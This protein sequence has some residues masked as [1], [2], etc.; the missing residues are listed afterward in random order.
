VN[1]ERRTTRRPARRGPTDALGG[2]TGYLLPLF[3]IPAALVFGPLGAAGSPAALFGLGCLGWWA[4]ARMLPDSWAA[5][6]RQPVRVALAVLAIAMFASYLVGNLRPLAADE[7]SSADR[8]LLMLLS[9]CGLALAAADLL[10]TRASV[11]ALLKRIVVFGS[12]VALIGAVQ[13]MTGLDPSGLVKIPGL[14]VNGVPQAIQT[15]GPIRRVAGTAS[16]P[17]EY[18]MVLALILPFALHFTFLATTRKKAWWTMTILIGV[19]MPMSLSRSAMLGTAVGLVALFVIWPPQRRL[20]AIALSP[21]L[22]VC[23]R[24]AIP[25]LVGTMFSLFSNASDDPSLQGRADSRAA[26]G[27]LI[28]KSPWFGRGFNTY[29]PE[30]FVELGLKGVNHG[31]LDNQ[32]LGTV[33]EMGFV[34]LAAL[35]L[36]LVI[37][38]GVARGIRLRAQQPETRDLGQAFLAAFLAVAVGMGT[39]DGMGFPQF[40]GLFMLLLGVAGALWRITREDWQQAQHERAAE[41]VA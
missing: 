16:H 7:L 14:S 6:G 39:F 3:L 40:M 23:M 5:R 24:L 29:I 37:S 12:V 32:Y 2:L 13:F 22:V 26:A 20:M 15:G 38:L 10:R 36:A 34:G 30:N 35:V 21:V 18:G 8:G 28:S 25:G 1:G 4:V 17:I 41:A 33:V 9:W 19:A 11:E 31:S 27:A